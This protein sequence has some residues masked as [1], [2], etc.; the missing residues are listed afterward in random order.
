MVSKELVC[1]AGNFLFQNLGG[2]VSPSGTFLGEI[3]G[4]CCRT[5]LSAVFSS[6]CVAS[7]QACETSRLGPPS[8]IADLS[9]FWAIFQICTLIKEV[10]CVARV[11]TFEISRLVTGLV[12]VDGNS[13]GERKGLFVIDQRIRPMAGGS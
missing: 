10:F 3:I 13:R 9:L 12:T 6:C 7:L 8:R 5:G 11:N 4:L 1:V 2:V